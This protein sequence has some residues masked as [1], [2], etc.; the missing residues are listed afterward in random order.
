MVLLIIVKRVGQHREHIF[1][2]CARNFRLYISV[3][4]QPLAETNRG[5][6]QKTPDLP[7]LDKKN[8]PIGVVYFTVGNNV[9]DV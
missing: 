4:F 2:L 9:N 6:W 5:Q 1:I 8:E 7:S 3:H